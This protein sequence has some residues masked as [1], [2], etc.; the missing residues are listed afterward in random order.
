MNKKVEV[1]YSFFCPYNTNENMLWT[2]VTFNAT[3][4]LTSVAIKVCF[5]APNNFNF[6]SQTLLCITHNRDYSSLGHLFSLCRTEENSYAL[7]FTLFEGRR[8][9][10]PQNLV[11]KT[12]VL[13]QFIPK[14]EFAH[15]YYIQTALWSPLVLSSTYFFQFW[16]T[17]HS[18]WNFATK[19]SVYT[20]TITMTGTILFYMKGSIVYRICCW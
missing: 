12:S 20:S 7:S 16:S 10:V 4:S 19:S 8:T 1:N 2:L 18:D 9:L 17:P 13:G 3:I 11:P 14:R 15:T 5:T 6:F